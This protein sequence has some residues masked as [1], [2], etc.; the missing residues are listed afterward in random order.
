MSREQ[1][2]VALAK[3]SAQL[4]DQQRTVQK[5][6]SAQ[7]DSQRAVVSGVAAS[8][9]E[10]IGLAMPAK[11]PQGRGGS[12]SAGEQ[13]L[14]AEKAA[15]HAEKE[16]KRARQQKMTQELDFY[17]LHWGRQVIQ[18]HE[19]GLHVASAGWGWGLGRDVYYNGPKMIRSHNDDP[20]MI[21]KESQ[22]DP[23]RCQSYAK[24][25]P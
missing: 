10:A 4:A 23:T 21:T 8:R 15:K 18:F 5:Q 19:Y 17:L 13:K 12:G 20:N 1:K 7:T 9:V 22:N 6:A 3:F 2:V 16:D 24:L 11:G 25:V 14:A